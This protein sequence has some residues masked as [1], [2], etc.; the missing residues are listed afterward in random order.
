MT[1]KCFD[2]FRMTDVNSDDY[3]IQ[4][5]SDQAPTSKKLSKAVRRRLG[6]L[7]DHVDQTVAEVIRERGGSASNVREAGHWADHT[8]GEAALAAASGDASAV[9]ALKIAKDARRLGQLY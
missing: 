1:E 3:S 4:Q 9:K 7:E 5:T 2:I 8:L 6:T